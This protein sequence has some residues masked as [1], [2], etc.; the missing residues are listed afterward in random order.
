MKEIEYH[1]TN[2]Y[3]NYLWTRF[4]QEKKEQFI[5]L[6]PKDIISIGD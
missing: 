6:N 4:P 3:S 2:A 5:F 1:Y